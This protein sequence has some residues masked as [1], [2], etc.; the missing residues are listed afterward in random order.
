MRQAAMLGLAMTLACAAT[1]SEDPAPDDEAEVG[2]IFEVPTFVEPANDEATIPV[3]RDDDLALSVRGIRPGFTRVFIDEQS[4]GTGL[5]DHGPISLSPDVLTL[6]LAGALVVGEHTLQLRTLTPDE[7]LESEVVSLLV[8]DAQYTG[9]TASMSDTVAFEADVIDAQGHGDEG[10]LMGYDLG[11]DPV[12]VTLAASQNGGWAIADRVTVPLAGFDRSG[13]PRFTATAALRERDE[14]R[15]LR[16]AWRTGEEG[17]ALLGSDMLWPAATVHTQAVVELVEQFDSFEYSRLGRPLILGDTLVVEALLAPDVEQPIPGSRTLLTSY[18]DPDTGR[19]GPPKVSAVGEG[20]DI[21]RIEPV[22]DLLTHA[23]GGTPGFSA[24]VAGLRAVVFEVDSGTGTLS[25]RPTGAS[26]RFSTLGDADGPA[27]TIVGALDSRHVFVPLEAERP[28]VFFRQFDDRPGGGSED[29][30]PGLDELGDIGE[31]SA[32]ITSTVL[33][34][35]PLYLVP[36]GTQTPVA[37]IL[38]TGDTPRVVLL[39]GLACDEIAV[40]IVSTDSMT[41]E[42]SAACRR[43]RD[44][45]RS[46][47]RLEETE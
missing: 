7:T 45:H 38:S 46:T 40:P 31:F 47:I 22:R 18:I 26:D 8:V 23:R 36:Q 33:G 19:Y 27:H 29:V 43:G 44:V 30:S 10:V 6:H 15:R 35:L 28:R 16:I 24:R 5:D 3:D 14:T 13:E 42:L 11:T 17:R 25:E 32:P 41:L 1:G 34:G 4:V 2:E 37:A 9:V 20:R 12:S 21:D 39:E